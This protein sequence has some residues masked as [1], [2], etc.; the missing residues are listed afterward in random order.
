[1]LKR[2][3]ESSSDS[4]DSYDDDV[5]EYGDE[6]TNTKISNISGKFLREFV[7]HTEPKSGF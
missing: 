3:R 7:M 6:S 2:R 4:S 5:Q 1:M